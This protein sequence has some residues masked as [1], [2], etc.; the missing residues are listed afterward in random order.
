MLGE[1]GKPVV[2]GF[3]DGG[4]E[5]E[6]VLKTALENEAIVDEHF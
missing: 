5:E 1:V 4:E 2:L 3:L 6:D